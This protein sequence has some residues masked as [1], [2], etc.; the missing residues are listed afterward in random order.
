MFAPPTGVRLGYA[1]YT[2]RESQILAP[3]LPVDDISPGTPGFFL[4]DGDFVYRLW[5]EVAFPFI[6]VYIYTFLY[7]LVVLYPYLLRQL[8]GKR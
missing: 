3:I 5:D 2:G 1:Q 8:F 6:F 4:W 7:H